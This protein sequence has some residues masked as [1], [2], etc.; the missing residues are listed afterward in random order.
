[1][2][3]KNSRLVK[4][5]DFQKI[6]KG[7]GSLSGDF[8]ILKF[9]ATKE[10]ILKIGFVVSARVAKDAV[11]RNKC[12]RRLREAV[13]ALIPLLENNYLCF[14]IAKKKILDMDFQQVKNEIKALSRRAGLLRD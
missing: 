7:G 4:N 1:M 11:A 3:P 2:L 10:K 5:S 8:L 12:K 9:L 13:R 6:Y 14:F